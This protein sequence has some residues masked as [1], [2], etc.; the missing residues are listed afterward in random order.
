MAGRHPFRSNSRASR[1]SPSTPARKVSR[2]RANSALSQDANEN[3]D[4]L[5]QWLETTPTPAPEET[6]NSIPAVS[7][8]PAVPAAP[9]ANTATDSCSST[10]TAVDVE[11]DAA[12]RFSQCSTLV[13]SSADA[14]EQVGPDV[15]VNVAVTYNISASLAASIMRP[16]PPLPG[17]APAPPT[18]NRTP[19]PP[20]PDRRGEMTLAQAT[21]ER[22]QRELR[23]ETETRPSSRG[24]HN[25]VERAGG[26]WEGARRRLSRLMHTVRGEG[27]QRREEQRQA[28]L[29]ELERRAVE[30]RLK[31]LGL[32]DEEVMRLEERERRRRREREEQLRR[33]G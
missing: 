3:S 30:R 7:P 2:D 4:R 12:S 1:P 17:E 22:S 18:P 11:S 29:R 16:L 27:R 20:P 9:V 10:T 31:E 15:T 24:R 26:R 25:E 19:P 28:E 5:G 23:R 6:S 8:G 21:Q 13:N 33:G 14:Q 32:A